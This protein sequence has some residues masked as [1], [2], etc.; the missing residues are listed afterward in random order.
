M[1]FI[2][3]VNHFPAIGEYCAFDCRGANINSDPH[4]MPLS[5]SVFDKEVCL[6]L[7]K[8]KKMI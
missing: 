4:N 2:S 1:A 3:A 7:F 8:N 5:R 6:S